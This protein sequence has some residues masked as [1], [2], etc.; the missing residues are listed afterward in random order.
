METEKPY[1]SSVKEDFN[2]LDLPLED[3][4]GNTFGSLHESMKYLL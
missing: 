1:S 2:G 4:K 3:F